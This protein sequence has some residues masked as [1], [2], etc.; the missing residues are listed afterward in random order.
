M[1]G[2]A[3]S[4]CI[5]VLQ[6]NVCTENCIFVCLF[7]ITA[8]ADIA[9][10][11]KRDYATAYKTN[12][13]AQW[14]DITKA[15]KPII[16]AVNGF[17]LGGGCELAM[18]CDIMLAGSKAQFGQYVHMLCYCLTCLPPNTY[19]IYLFTLLFDPFSFV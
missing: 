19:C 18:M 3:I 2:I 11:S 17:A 7:H 5:T 13:F 8:G 1:H 9:E 12:M 15:S 10:M 4:D 6:Q 14:A 16:A